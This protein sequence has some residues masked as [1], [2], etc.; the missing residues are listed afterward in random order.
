MHL[1]TRKLSGFTILELLIVIAI[2]IFLG[3]MMM[4]R[5]QALYTK[6]RQTEVT[7]NLST[8][9]AAQQAYQL[10]HGHF[11]TNFKELEWQ[12]KGY[13]A[14]PNTTQNTYTYGAASNT[15]QEGISYFTG[16]TNT[17][18]SLLAG[19]SLTPQQFTIYA[20][21]KNDTT[22]ERWQLNHA[23]DIALIPTTAN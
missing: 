1:L 2:I 7:L 8:L 11:A 20:V 9:Y 5:Y 10:Q 4:P 13:T 23:G 21:L 22:L 14:N 17:P 6:T 12:P 15:P 19:S 18:A 16:S 3:K